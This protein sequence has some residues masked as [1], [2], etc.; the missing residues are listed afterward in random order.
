MEERNK[1][2]EEQ[3]CVCVLFAR[4]LFGSELDCSAFIEGTSLLPH[5]TRGVRKTRNHII[6]AKT[7]IVVSIQGFKRFFFCN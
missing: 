1:D 3:R 6:T 7:Y 5:K 4:E 2:E